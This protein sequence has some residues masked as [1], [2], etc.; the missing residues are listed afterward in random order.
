MILKAG[1]IS[2]LTLLILFLLSISMSFD[3]ATSVVPGW[4]TTVYH[5]FSISNRFVIIFLSLATIGYWHLAKRGVKINTTLF[6]GHLMLTIP[7]L[8]FMRVPPLFIGS[9]HSIHDKIINQLIFREQLLKVT[10]ILFLGQ[11]I[12][13]IYYFKAIISQRKT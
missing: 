7:A 6:V 5:P 13:L 11:V 8:I 9:D 1:Y 2:F 4:H 10:T 12:F 3:F